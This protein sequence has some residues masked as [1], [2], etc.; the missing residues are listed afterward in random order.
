MNYI[1]KSIL[2]EFKK[3]GFIYLPNFLTDDEVD[4]INKYR[5]NIIVNEARD[6][7][8][9]SNKK[10]LSSKLNQSIHNPLLLVGTYRNLYQYPL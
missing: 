5:E 3:N 1:S 4:K 7:Y 10:L 9:I 2:S 6:L 8:T